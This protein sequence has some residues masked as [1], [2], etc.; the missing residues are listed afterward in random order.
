MEYNKVTKVPKHITCELSDIIYLITCKKGKKYY[1]GET[2]HPFSYIFI[3]LYIVPL[4]L[5]ILTVVSIKLIDLLLNSCVNL[6]YSWMLL[7][8]L[9]NFSNSSVPWVQIMN[10]SSMN[11]NHIRVL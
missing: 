9:K 4:L 7:R 1:V 11:L 2:G 3:G 6:I 10:M 8:Y 5:P